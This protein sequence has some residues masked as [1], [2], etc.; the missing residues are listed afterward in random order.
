MKVESSPKLI[1][2]IIVSND[3]YKRTKFKIDEDIKKWLNEP[4]FSDLKLSKKEIKKWYPTILKII[5]EIKECEKLPDDKC[6]N[7]NAHHIVLKRNNN[8]ELYLASI[9]CHKLEKINQLNA[10]KKNYLISHLSPRKMN[11]RL[12]SE[13]FGRKLVESKHKL[14]SAFAK[15]INDKCEL[16]GFYIY[17]DTGIGKSYAATAFANE[18]ARKDLKISFVFVPQIVHDIKQGFNDEF[19]NNKE[20]INYLKQC[21]VLFLDDIGAEDT[22]SWFYDD[23]LLIILNYRMEL[24]KPTFFIS[25]LSIN[26]LEEKLVRTKSFNNI[27]AKRLIER[28]R[29]LTKNKEYLI[30][31]KNM[32]Y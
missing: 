7:L 30:K 4:L 26:E 25:N 2:E 8:N 20:I 17:G 15:M 19:N 23:Y 32:R 1:K 18:L 11:I 13:F 14:I 27:N 10:F 12:N 24:E 29:A 31:D 3:G 6:C 21:D 28:I 22:S 5:D 9:P 16:Q